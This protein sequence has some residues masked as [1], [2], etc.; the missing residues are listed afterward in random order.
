MPE[1]V[2]RVPSTRIGSTASESW[3]NTLTIGEELPSICL[4]CSK[5]GG[6]ADLRQQ[7]LCYLALGYTD[8]QIARRLSLS[9]RTVRRRI[10]D[11]MEELNAT[12]RFAAGVKATQEGRIC[13][14]LD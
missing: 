6:R 14:K 8:E 1:L 13:R 4:V 10:A 7:I 5:S 11:V 3:D 9:V 2:S 12:S